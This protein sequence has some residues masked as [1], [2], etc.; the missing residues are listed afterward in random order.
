MKLPYRCRKSGGA[1]ADAQA[2][3]IGNSKR[4][5]AWVSIFCVRSGIPGYSGE[6][7]IVG[8]NICAESDTAASLQGEWAAVAIPW[9][10]AM[11]ADSR[12]LMSLLACRATAEPAFSSVVMLAGVI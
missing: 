10:S 3:A 4:V 8:G 7:A 12:S 5:R 6:V 11:T 9:L 1:G 2:D